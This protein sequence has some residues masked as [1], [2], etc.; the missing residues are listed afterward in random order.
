MPLPIAKFL[1]QHKEELLFGFAIVMLIV[2]S[3]IAWNYYDIKVFMEWAKIAENKNILSIY[4][5][6][7]KAGYMPLVPIVFILTYIISKALIAFIINLANIAS[8]TFYIDFM[9]LLMRIPLMLAI[10]LTGY[11]L[12][13]K[14]GWK[15]AKWWIFGIPVWI[16]Y[17]A[18]Q[19]DPLMVLFMV[20]GAYSFV[21]RKYDKAG[22]FWG[23]GTALKFVPIILVPLAFKVLRHRRKELGKF[24]LFFITPIIA[25]SLPFLIY[26]PVLMIKKVLEFHASRYPQML[27]LF[28]VPMLIS[29]YEFAYANILSWIWIPIFILIYIFILVKAD[30]REGNKEAIFKVIGSLVLAFI[31]FNKVQNPQYILWAY[32]F[33]TYTL[34]RKEKNIFKYVLLLATLTGSLIYPLLYYFPPAVLDEEI[35]IEEDMT[36]YN[37]KEL[38]LM[39]FEGSAKF[40]VENIIA[41]F[42]VRFYELMEYLYTHFNILGALTVLVHNVLLIVLLCNFIPKPITTLRLD[43][44]VLLRVLK[45]LRM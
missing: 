32:P 8:S 28:N 26:N 4:S 7:R 3:W 9:K 27:S 30:I 42:R 11:I 25:I 40:I 44:Q 22:L 13:K 23:L 6:A 39:S 35:I 34:S 43:R 1:K 16:V 29:N 17:L 36:P 2:T 45:R 15:V 14:E 10:A 38:L 20:L 33:I 19:F 18:Y 12:Y 31:I 5:D 41:F 21:E 37:A 24:L